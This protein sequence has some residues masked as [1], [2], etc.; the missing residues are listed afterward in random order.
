MI[1]RRRANVRRL[2]SAG[3]GAAPPREGSQAGAAQAGR[4]VTAAG[5]GAAS[6]QRGGA[7]ENSGPAGG[8]SGAAQPRGGGQTPSVREGT[9][10]RGAEEDAPRGV[11][12]MA[13]RRQ[14]RRAAKGAERSRAC[15]I[16]L[17][18][19]GGE[20]LMELGCRHVYHEACVVRWFL[21]RRTCPQCRYEVEP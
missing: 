14:Q 11:S 1:S 21:R 10:P 5:A 15:S 12:R 2:L 17:A 19:L 4:S 13:L 18:A 6:G 16:C 8:A 7:S 20:R 3:A 9:A